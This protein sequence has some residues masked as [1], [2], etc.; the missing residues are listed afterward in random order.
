MHFPAFLPAV[1]STFFL[2]Y[3]K[4]IIINW[5]IATIKAPKAKLPKW[6]LIPLLK[7]FNIGWF[8]VPFSLVKYQIHADEAYTNWL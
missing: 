4:N 1:A 6:Y 8:S 7:D 2:R 3:S 5:I